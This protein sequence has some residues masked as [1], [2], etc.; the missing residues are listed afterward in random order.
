MLFRS[1]PLGY[2]KYGTVG[3]L[4]N[5]PPSVGG[6]AALYPGGYGYTLLETYGVW[7]LVV[8]IMYP[9]VKLRDQRS[10]TPS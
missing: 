5:P 10:N 9:L 7:L 3:F 8:A 2:L 6:A 4:L 1:F